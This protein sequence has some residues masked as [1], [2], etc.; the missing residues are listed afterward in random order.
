MNPLVLLEQVA[1]RSGPVSILTSVS[2]HLEPGTSLGI[3]G[4]NGVGKTTALRVCATL[5]R[6][7]AGRGAVLGADLG[8]AASL[9]KRARIGLSGHEPAAIGELTLAENLELVAKL[10]DRPS[11]WVV[12]ALAKVGLDRAADRRVD[13]CSHGKRRRLD[14]AR[15]LLTE[16]DLLLLDEAQAGLDPPAVAVIGKLVADVKSRGGGAVLVSH[17]EAALRAVCDRVVTMRVGEIP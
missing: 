2:I 3:A 12:E 7:S 17:D 16:P 14:L 5:Q 8:T 1:V 10:S 9:A 11:A 6:I 13:R 4:A 15:L